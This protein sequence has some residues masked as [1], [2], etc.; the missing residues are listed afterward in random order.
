MNINGWVDDPADFEDQLAAMSE[1]LF[2][3]AAT[4]LKDSGKGKVVLLYDVLREIAG[5]IPEPLQTSAP[6]CVSHACASALDL[7]KAVEIKTGDREEWLSR[8]A[9]EPIYSTARVQIGRMRYSRGTTNTHAIQAMIKFGTLRRDKYGKVDLTDYSSSRAV[10][11]GRQELPKSLIDISRDHPINDFNLIQNYEQ[12]RDAMANGFPVVVASNQGF[13]SKR[14]KEGF[15]KPSGTWNHSMCCAAVD[16][17]YSR[18]AILILN[19]WPKYLSG[20]TRHNNPPSSF[21]C[22]AEVFNRMCR[23]KD[24]YCMVD[25]N[26]YRKREINTE[27][28]W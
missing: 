18:P 9:C 20:P 8:T 23:H 7:L 12:A 11:W 4:I 3:S 17:A 21:W 10:S 19:S 5:Y 1:P 14:D 15:C 26:G 22:D 6:D 24:T 27:V 25:F 28:G 13:T 16:D 2:S